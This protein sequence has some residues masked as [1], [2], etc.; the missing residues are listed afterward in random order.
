MYLK[1]LSL[2]NFKNY[3]SL[4]AQFSPKI[5]C[6]VGNNGMG[7]TNL[8]DAIYYL[9]F[10]KSFFNS[11]DSQN[12]THH[13]NFFVL[14]GLFSSGNEDIEIYC[15]IKKNHKKIFKRNKTEYERLSDHIGQIP[16]VMIS[17]DDIEI[18]NGSSETRRKFLD[19]IISQYD[20]HYLEKLILY[21]QAL[22]Q[23]N[24][25]L[26]QFHETRNFL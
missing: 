8:L 7:K 14:Q 21:N 25:L 24:A 22:K 11:I 19:S 13:E 3:A 1:Q 4:E 20:K 5:N 6:F 18:I 2:I 12:I 10:C 26:K 23:R 17:P 16:L 15:G 9:S